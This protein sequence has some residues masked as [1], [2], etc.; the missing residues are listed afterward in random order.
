MT[1]A[2]LILFALVALSG[3]ASSQAWGWYVIDPTTTQGQTNIQFLIG[4][5]WTTIFLSLIAA[6]ISMS[7]GLA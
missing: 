1:R 4:G 6:V 7:L 2:A 3:C 5:F